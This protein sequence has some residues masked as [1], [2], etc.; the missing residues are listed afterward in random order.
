MYCGL[1]VLIRQLATRLNFSGFKTEQS[2]TRVQ[3]LT[4]SVSMFTKP[5]FEPLDR[6]PEQEGGLLIF[7]SFSNCFKSIFSHFKT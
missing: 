7:P 3:L 4:N 6:A 1:Q 5:E 2:Y